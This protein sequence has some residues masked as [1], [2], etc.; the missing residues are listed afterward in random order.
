[1]GWRVE[2]ISVNANELGGFKEVVAN[3]AGQGSSPS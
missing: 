3:I 2:M 1:M